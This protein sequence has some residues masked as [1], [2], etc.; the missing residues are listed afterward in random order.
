[1]RVFKRE[2]CE[3]E[4]GATMLEYSLLASL[5]GV[6]LIGSISSAS[7]RTAGTFAIA[8]CAIACKAGGPGRESD[9]AYRDPAF[10]P[11]AYAWLT[12]G[13]DGKGQGECKNPKDRYACAAETLLRRVAQYCS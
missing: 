5:L 2:R 7:G 12:G 9:G 8:T 4:R 3:G 11:V 1:M 6:A 10:C 13:R